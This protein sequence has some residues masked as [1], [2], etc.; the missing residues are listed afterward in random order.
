[1]KY[2]YP[3]IRDLRED[4]DKTQADIAKIL[5]THTTQYRRWEKGESGIPVH[6]LIELCKYYNVSTDY[7]IGLKNRNI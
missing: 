2:I 7:I 4:K 1:M 3:R 5:N 6:K